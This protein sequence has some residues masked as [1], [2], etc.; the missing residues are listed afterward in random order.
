M[1]MTRQQQLIL[2]YKDVYFSTNN[3]NPS[4]PSGVV[5]LLQDFDDLFREEIPNGLHPLRGI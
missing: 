4:L 2:L 3:C 1:M 5:T